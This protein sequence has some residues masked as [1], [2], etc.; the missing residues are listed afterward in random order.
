MPLTVYFDTNVFFDIFEARDP[1]LFPKLQNLVNAGRLQ[2]LAS[3]INILEFLAGN[4]L[5]G[6]APAVSRLFS[7]SPSWLYLTG[8]AKREVVFAFDEPRR[9]RS[10]LPLADRYDWPGLLPLIVEK[11]ALT[12]IPDLSIPT[13]AAL[14]AAYPP[15]S[16]KKREDFW[17]NELSEMQTTIRDELVYVRTC[18]NIFRKVVASVLKVNLGRARDLADK[19]L[20]NP[21]TAPAFRLEVEL[22]CHVLRVA[23]PRWNRNDFMDHIHAGIF[24]YVDLFVTRDGLGKKPGLIQKIK[25]FD[26]NI[27][28]PRG[29]DRYTDRLC[30]GF[31]ELERRV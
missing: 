15:G 4:H 25:W 5:P 20:A 2:V 16:I 3:D 7:V 31:E 30:A 11:D 6:F 10:L 9:A 29:L 21:D 22:T 24:G 26:D 28:V 14:V 8:L 13:D 27:R 17:Q 1:T 18:D 19:L 23:I 12:A